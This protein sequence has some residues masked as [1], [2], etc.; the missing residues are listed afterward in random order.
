MLKS[1]PQIV[2]LNGHACTA[3]Q[4][5]E[6]NWIYYTLKV[7]PLTMMSLLPEQTALHPLEL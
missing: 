2:S 5:P 7:C 4:V 3:V 6:F 1:F